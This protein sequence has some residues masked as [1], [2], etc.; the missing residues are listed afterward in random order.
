M[1]SMQLIIFHQIQW[2]RRKSFVEN[3][4]DKDP[5]GSFTLNNKTIVTSL[6][7]FTIAIVIGQCEWI[8]KVNIKSAQNQKRK[9]KKT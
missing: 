8:P 3:S 5:N 6:S 7:P 9:N 2:I 4:N 1:L